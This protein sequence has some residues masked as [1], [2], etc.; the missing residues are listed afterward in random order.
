MEFRKCTYLRVYFGN[1]FDRLISEK[2]QK[3][4]HASLIHYP[5]FEY[6]DGGIFFCR[7]IPGVACGTHTIGRPR[8]GPLQ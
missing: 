2:R 1:G 8:G 3:K 7:A 4:K 5:P 6:D